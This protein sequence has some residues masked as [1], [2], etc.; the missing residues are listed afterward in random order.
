MAQVGLNALVQKS[1]GPTMR[2]SA[3]AAQFAAFD[4]IIGFGSLGLG[5]LAVVMGYG[6]MYAVAGGITLVGL[7]VWLRMSATVGK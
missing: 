4:L 6:V 2:G 5:W 1:A 3:A 7:G